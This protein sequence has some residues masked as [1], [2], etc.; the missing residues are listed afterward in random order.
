LEDRNSTC[1]FMA[2]NQSVRF[3]RW[4]KGVSAL[5]DELGLHRVSG[6]RAT[7]G[8]T[9]CCTP[10]VSILWRLGI[11]MS[12]HR[13]VPSDEPWADAGKKQH[14]GD[15]IECPIG[16]LHSVDAHATEHQMAVLADSDRRQLS[17]NAKPD[18]KRRKTSRHDE[19]KASRDSLSESV[20]ISI[21]QVMF[22]GAQSVR[23][24]LGARAVSALRVERGLRHVSGAEPQVVR[25]P[26]QTTMNDRRVNTMKPYILRTSKTVE[27]QNRKPES[28]DH[29]AGGGLD[30]PCQ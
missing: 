19:T 23:L 2:R 18:G 20:G 21:F 22:D 10:F 17:E 29:P 4:A 13:H 16:H 28:A 25:L 6:V 15:E 9:L 3:S 5:R 30:S 27:P 12:S 24:S 26:P 11:F 1:V 7:I 14:P 8:M